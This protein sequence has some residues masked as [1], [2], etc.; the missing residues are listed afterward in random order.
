MVKIRK[1][2]IEDLEQIVEIAQKVELNRDSSK[3]EGFIVYVLD[4]ESYTSRIEISN[5]FYVAESEEGL[6]GYLM[7]YSQDEFQQIYNSG[8]LNHEDNLSQVISKIEGKFI[9]RDQIALMPGTERNGIGNAL[10]KK[11]FE[12]MQN[13]GIFRMYVGVLE[14]PMRNLA[15]EK[16]VVALGFYKF[17]SINN[18]DGTQW[19]IYLRN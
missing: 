9:F 6:W 1:A 13:E 3:K 11:L 7:C 8:E 5:H 16:F 4:S 10:M 12:D 17:E 15:S 19:G 18:G 2:N 14:E